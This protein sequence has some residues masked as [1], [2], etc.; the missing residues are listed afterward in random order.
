MTD[1]SL[2]TPYFRF[3]YAKWAD[4]WERFGE[5]PSLEGLRVLDFGCGLGS[6]AV[7]AA[8]EGAVAVGQD[9]SSSS[10][11]E[12]RIIVGESYPELDVTF[13]D[14]PIGQ[15]E[16]QFDVIVTNETLEHVIDLPACLVA[17]HDRLAPGGRMYAGW[18][19]LWFSPLGGH[20]DVSRVGRFPIP[21]SHLVKRQSRASDGE[22]V[23]RIGGESA[24]ALNHLRYRDYVRIIDESPFDVVSFRTN[25]G[26]H[27]MYRL[28]RAGARLAKDPFVA[29]IY[30][31]LRRHQA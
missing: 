14:T 2:H 15:M 12:A 11:R 28:L 3:K 1:A 27:A 30:A 4:F 20:W 24:I 8:E 18:G 6:F 25:V 19:P 23:D 10:I 5:R 29:N 16:E 9:L 22:Y 21:W 17:L 13:V 26:R 7:H 31:I